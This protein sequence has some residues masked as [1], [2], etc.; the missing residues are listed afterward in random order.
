MGNTET[1]DICD[2]C[3]GEYLCLKCYKYYCNHH[4]TQHSCFD[5]PNYCK[6]CPTISTNQCKK[7]KFNYCDNHI[8]LH[9]PCI[10]DCKKC[11]YAITYC[12]KCNINITKYS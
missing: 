10:T 8:S 5:N 4:I 11:I 7:C 2:K 9:N 3:P 12:N 1:L 6:L